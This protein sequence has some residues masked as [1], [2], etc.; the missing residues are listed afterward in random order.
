MLTLS[1][2]A[3]ALNGFFNGADAEFSAVTTDTRVLQRGDLFVA[4]IGPN[5][6]GHGFLGE[7]QAKGA[8]GA[9]VSRAIQESIAT[10]TVADTRFA[11]GQLAAHWRGR[12]SI[13]V[14]AVTGS[15]G[16]TTVKNMLAAIM[17]ETG[18]GL[19][20]QGNLNNDIGVPLTLLR[21]K[22]G[23]RYAVIEMGMNH[24]GEIEYLTR[25]TRPT[26]AL[27]TNAGEAHLAGLGSIEAVARAKG[28][29]FSGLAQDGV[30]V[31]NVD[32]A[33]AGMWRTLA[34]PRRCLSFGLQHPADVSADY[35]IAITGSI[36][37]LKTSLGESEIRLSLLGKHNVMNALAAAAASLAAGV[38]LHDIR[39]GLEKLKTISGRLEIKKGANGARVL[40][41]TYNA[42]P[43]S[44]VA[45]VEVL[46][47]A[48]GERVLVL[49]DMAELGAT[50]ADIH[51][52]AGE[53][54]RQLGV[55]KLYA[56]GELSR[57]A[58]MGFGD[59]AHHYRSQEE[60][61]EAL[62]IAMHSDMTVLVKGSRVMRMEKVVEKI[63][64]SSNQRDD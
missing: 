22:H 5:F 11:L 33:H 55:H 28:E 45:G 34:A 29:I 31:I 63:T 54:A 23:D 51:R 18:A 32:D 62:L 42:N 7:A 25:L 2:T 58:V 15:N 19:A 40:D 57:N 41:D 3:Q 12:F 10:I 13:P 14:V 1:A 24:S 44:L 20:T 47:E 61:V 30:A 64:A 16:K 37:R 35:T 50:A 43:S 26:V 8:A 52:R 59:G 4:L 36:I 27:I 17:A 39:N 21:L 9:L 46:K 48:D 56:V 38:K 6:D 49:G 53:L 60:L